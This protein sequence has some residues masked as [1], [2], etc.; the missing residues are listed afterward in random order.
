MAPKPP[1]PQRIGIF[2]V[3]SANVPGQ[4]KKK[5]QTAGLPPP[6]PVPKP[7][8]KKKAPPGSPGS[9]FNVFINAHPNMRPYADSIWKWAQRYGVDPAVMATLFWR[10]SF[11][12]TAT[13]GQD[14]STVTSPAG[15]VGIGQIMPLHVGEKTPWG[16]IV[17]QSDLTN[18]EFN[19]HWST[20]YFSN[21]VAKYGSADAAYSQGYNPG[22]TGPALT[23]LL[24]KG[25]VPRAGLTPQ[26][27]GQATV[28]QKTATAQ[29]QAVA[30]DKWVVRNPNGTIGFAAI[31][32]AAHPPKGIIRV[33]G[34]L[35][36]TQSQLL[37]AKQNIYDDLYLSFQGRPAPLRAVA[38]ILEK[39]MS[40]L[41]VMYAL[42]TKPKKG[43]DRFVGSPIWNR[44]A[45]GITGRAKDLY[46]QNWK[47][48]RDLIRKAIVESWDAPTIDAKLRSRPEYL[49]GPEFKT[50]VAQLSN[51]FQSI[52]GTPSA[53]AQ[54]T[55]KEAAGNGWAVDQFAYWLRGQPEYTSSP[56]YL[57]KTL[58]L[59]SA[60]GLITGQVP[61]LGQGTPPPNLQ[62]PGG[63]LPNNQLVP[64]KPQGIGSRPPLV[65]GGKS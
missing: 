28:E 56:E 2:G 16:H 17:S 63:K 40:Q 26:E 23:S 9:A 57:Q 53:E 49:N 29:A 45:A 44:T 36:L 48:D 35:P 62:P 25:Y 51:V 54:Q 43:P 14:P 55:I 19:I 5:K 13:S 42:T 6:P 30:Y 38:N 52:Y 31:R 3:G 46:G 12:V 39:G 8:P 59:G 15:A 1:P 50:N 18:P 41:G 4:P 64:G 10:E 24:P 20:W 33:Q 22:Y 32:D 47:P 34:G 7:E 65:V 60:L 37:Q 21:A 27:K 11:S 58:S 61:T